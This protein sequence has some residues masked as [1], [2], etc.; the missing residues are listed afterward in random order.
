M[1]WEASLSGYYDQLT[2]VNTHK[3]KHF[4]KCK[5][6]S[7]ITMAFNLANLASE[8]DTLLLTNRS[9]NE[10]LNSLFVCLFI[11]FI[12]VNSMLVRALL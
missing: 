3:L 4:I 1:G 5:V 6:L 7:V 8:V 12:F 11:F 10:F 9:E 2:M